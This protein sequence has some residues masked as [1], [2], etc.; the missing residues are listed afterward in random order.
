MMYNPL[1]PVTVALRMVELPL[2]TRPRSGG[3][4]STSKTPPGEFFDRINVRQRPS[5]LDKALVVSLA[6]AAQ[7]S[8]HYSPSF[9]GSAYLKS[10]SVIGSA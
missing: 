1:S 2:G 7:P 4:E 3:P 9:A 6:P 5:P 8:Q 10:G